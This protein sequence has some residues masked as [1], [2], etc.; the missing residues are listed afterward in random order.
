MAKLVLIVLKCCFFVLYFSLPLFVIG[1]SIQNDITVLL[2]EQK[3]AGAVYSIVKNG[4]IS[5]YSSGLRNMETGDRMHK[6]DQVHVGSIAKTFLAMGIL[7]LATESRLRLDD[8]VKKY[9]KNLP[10]INP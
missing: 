6:D 5:C 8:P 3:L 2:K 7:R 4:R 1:Q 10:M 9:L